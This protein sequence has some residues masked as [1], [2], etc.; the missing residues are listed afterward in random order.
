VVFINSLKLRTLKYP[1]LLLILLSAIGMASAADIIVGEGTGN[2]T[3]NAALTNATEGDTIIVSD[4]TYTEN[5][6]V[7]KSVIIRSE[8]GSASTVVN[9]ASID[10]H[11]QCHGQQRYN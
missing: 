2:T 1:I 10:T 4:G 3:I 8:N 11:I 9:A 5:I 6:V 7:N